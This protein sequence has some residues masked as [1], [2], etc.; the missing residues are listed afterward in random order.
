MAVTGGCNGQLTFG[1]TMALGLTVYNRPILKV[2]STNS[3]QGTL[4]V[5]VTGN[6]KCL[7][8]HY[9]TRDGHRER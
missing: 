6:A 2:G 9:I 7:S 3:T 8:I 1:R 4:R 5:M